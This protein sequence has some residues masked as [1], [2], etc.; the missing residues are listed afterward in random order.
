MIV[1]TVSSGMPFYKYFFHIF[2]VFCV[3][4]FEKSMKM[5][6]SGMFLY[7]TLSNIRLMVSIYPVVDLFLRKPF[8]FRLRIGQF[9]V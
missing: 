2:A 1:L 6:V 8:W 3:R 4:C 5:I 9:L 7:I